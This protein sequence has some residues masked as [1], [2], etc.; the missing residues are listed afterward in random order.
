MLNED[1]TKFLVPAGT[2]DNSPPIHRWVIESRVHD[3][4]PPGTTD[5]VADQI[6]RRSES[7]H[8]ILPSL[9]GLDDPFD[10]RTHR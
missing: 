9:M 6:T 4:V 1:R 8:A 7:T 10:S 5:L 3:L 2:N